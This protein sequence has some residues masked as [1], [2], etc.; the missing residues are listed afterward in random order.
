MVSMEQPASRLVDVVPYCLVD[1]MPTFRDS[2]LATLYDR[3]V[4]DGNGYGEMAGGFR[5]FLGEVRDRSR[6]LY[7]VLVGGVP[8]GMLALTH[9]QER[10]AQAHLTVFREFWG[11][12]FQP[13]GRE[14]VRTVLEGLDGRGNPVWD[15]F[16]ALIPEQNRLAVAYARRCGFQNVGVV[17]F[18]W[19]DRNKSRSVPAVMLA[20]G[21]GDS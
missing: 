3:Q 14:A 21:R 1:G 5:Q 18:G 9:F 19:H 20:L 2:D 6:L 16:L 10:F 4:R 13:H 17:P 12:A 8:G 7:V 15:G 11:R